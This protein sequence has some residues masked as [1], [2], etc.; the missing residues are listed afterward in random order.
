MLCITV[1]RIHRRL[2]T[3][4]SLISKVRWINIWE[5]DYVLSAGAYCN[6]SKSSLVFPVILSFIYCLLT[7]RK[8][9]PLDRWLAMS[10]LHQYMTPSWRRI[11]SSELQ[12]SDVVAEKPMSDTVI[13]YCRITCLDWI[14]FPCG[15][16]LPNVNKGNQIVFHSRHSTSSDYCFAVHFHFYS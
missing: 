6:I 16:A 12:T 3:W 13:A 15:V 4:N 14:Y 5:V 1:S 11:F 10:R 7:G 8:K 2:S 9:T